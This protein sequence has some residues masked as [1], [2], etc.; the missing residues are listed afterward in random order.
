MLEQKARELISLAVAVMTQCD[1]CQET[2][3][4]DRTDC[5]F[6]GSCC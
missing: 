4:H 6:P 2:C 5:S 3:R 1:G